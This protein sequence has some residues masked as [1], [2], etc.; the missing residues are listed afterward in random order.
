M[1]IIPATKIIII[2]TLE[3]VSLP[4][5]TFPFKLDQTNYMIWKPQILPTIIGGNL[6][7]LLIDDIVEP[8]KYIMIRLLLILKQS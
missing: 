8:P 5:Y 3:Q 6:E 4:N 1:S 7:G 2:L